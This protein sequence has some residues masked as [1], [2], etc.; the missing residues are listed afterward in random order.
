MSGESRFPVLA[1]LDRWAKR[2]IDDLIASEEERDQAM[3][4]MVARMRD[5]GQRTVTFRKVDL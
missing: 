2:Q 4:E 1:W 5:S 3:D